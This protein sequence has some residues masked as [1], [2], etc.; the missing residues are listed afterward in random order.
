M[1]IVVRH[2]DAGLRNSWDGPDLMRPLTPL[3][4]RQADGLVVRLED[5]PLGRILSSPSTRCLQSVQPLAQDR[6][7]PIDS[8]GALGVAAGPAGI[9]ALWNRFP[10]DALMCTHGETIGRLFA[11]L[12]IGGLVTDAPPQWPKGSTWLLQRAAGA[13]VRA[14]YMAPLATDHHGRAGG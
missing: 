8:V 5:F 3:G 13:T 7:L 2:A 1:L 6:R 4:Y 11:R 10:F 12:A 14:R 9:L